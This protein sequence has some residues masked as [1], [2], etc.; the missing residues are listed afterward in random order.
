MDGAG[1]GGVRRDV[2][3]QHIT[4]GGAVERGKLPAAAAR[5]G[6]LHGKGHSAAQ[7]GARRWS[8]GEPWQLPGMDASITE[9]SLRRWPGCLPNLTG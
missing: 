3:H 6:A 1:Q 2:H 7:G 9:P 4:G 8:R 5:L